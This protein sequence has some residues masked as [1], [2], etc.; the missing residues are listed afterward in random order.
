MECELLLAFEGSG[1]PVLSGVGHLIDCEEA[2]DADPVAMDSRN[3]A[4]GET[5]IGHV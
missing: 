4:D 3:V 5:V 2:L 1:G